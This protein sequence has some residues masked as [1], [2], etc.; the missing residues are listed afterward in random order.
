MSVRITSAQLD[1]QSVAA[2]AACRLIVG[3]EAYGVLMEY[4]GYILVDINRAELRTADGLD[5][6]LNYTNVEID[7]AIDW[8]L[9]MGGN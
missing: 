3:A 8:L 2:G 7:A 6:M 4:L 9:D 1:P 5:Y